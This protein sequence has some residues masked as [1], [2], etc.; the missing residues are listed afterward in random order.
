MGNHGCFIFSGGECTTYEVA[1]MQQLQPD[2]VAQREKN[3]LDRWTRKPVKDLEE[4]NLL[5]AA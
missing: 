5:S 3:E 1:P 2:S 4:D